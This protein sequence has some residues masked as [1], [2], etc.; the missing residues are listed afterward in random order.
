MGYMN[1]YYEMANYDDCE[2]YWQFG[3]FD[4]ISAFGNSRT[5]D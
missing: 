3:D 4:T 2:W 5:S 1:M